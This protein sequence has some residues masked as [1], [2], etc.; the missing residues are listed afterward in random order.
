M[1]NLLQE[2]CNASVVGK[3]VEV[4]TEI[5][6]YIKETTLPTYVEVLEQNLK[7]IIES[8]DNLSLEEVT[9]DIFEEETS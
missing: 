6:E 7:Q 1:E 8:R 4:A 5:R 3:N 2:L 9:N